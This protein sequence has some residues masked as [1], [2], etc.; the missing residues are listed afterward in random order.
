LLFPSGPASLVETADL[1]VV[2]HCFAMQQQVWMPNRGS[3]QRTKTTHTI[4]TPANITHS[5][6]PI[7]MRLSVRYPAY[8]TAIRE[9]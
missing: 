6:Q 5:F 9:L 2:E 3:T 7:E 4:S 8:L 1:A